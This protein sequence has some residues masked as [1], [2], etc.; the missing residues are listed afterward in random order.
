MKKLKR[1]HFVSPGN[2]PCLDG[3]RVRGALQYR[4]A[5]VSGALLYGLAGI[6][7]AIA[8]SC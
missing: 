5:R 3:G 4:A 7:A 8:L 6:V 2:D 1:E